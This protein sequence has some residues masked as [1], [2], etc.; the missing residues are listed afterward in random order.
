MLKVISLALLF[1]ILIIFPA[2]KSITYILQSRYGNTLVKKVRRFE[3][4]DYELRKCKL[5]ITLLETC[6]EKNI[7]PKILSFRV[8]NLHLKTSRAYY[9]C[10]I[11]LLREEISKKKSKVKKFEKDFVLL[12]RKLTETLRIIGYIHLCCLFLNKNDRK[13][14]HQEDIHSKN[15]FDLGFGNSQTSHDPDKVI[16]NYSSHILTENEKDLLSKGLNFTIRHK[17]LKYADYLL[18]FELLYRDKHNLDITNEK[19]EVLKTRMEDCAFSSFNSYSENGAPLNLSREELAVLKSLSKNKNL[20]IPKSGKGKSI[21]IIDKSNYFETLQNI[22]SD[23]SKFTQVSVADGKQ[24]NF[25][26]HVE[27]H[28]TDLIKDLKALKLFLQLFVKL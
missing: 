13:F 10:Q 12:K 25:I 7:I 11:K 4:M 15:L 14:K 8:S 1:M 26:V 20:I 5:D 9:S 28:I 2:D 17:T 6:L 27:T 22:L 24:L 23:S 16:L 3:K 21:A 19:K 18:P